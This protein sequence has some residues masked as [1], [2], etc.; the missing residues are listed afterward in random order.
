MCAAFG[1]GA[2]VEAGCNYGSKEPEMARRTVSQIAPATVNRVCNSL[3]AA[4]E[5]AR[6]HDPLRIKNADAW[7][8]GLAGP[9]NAQTAGNVVIDDDT[10]QSLHRGRLPIRSELLVDVLATTGARP[11]QGNCCWSAEEVRHPARR[12]SLPRSGK[13]GSRP[14]RKN[15]ATAILR[16]AFGWRSGEGRLR[17]AARRTRR[18]SCAA[19]VRLGRGPRSRHYA[20]SDHEVVRAI[21]EDPRHHVAYCLRHSNITRMLLKNIPIRLIASLHNTSIHQIEKNYSRRSPSIRPTP[22]RAVLSEP[23]WHRQCRHAGA[24]INRGPQVKR[25]TARGAARRKQPGE[26]GSRVAEV[27]WRKSKDG[28]SVA[29]AGQLAKQAKAWRRP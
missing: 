2:F 26:Q 16:S 21:G 29:L 27:S 12:R 19:M 28:S 3:C 7:D 1:R 25:M 18:C 11:I 10:V 5:L 17:R 24:V 23:P 6:L 13:G 9:P 8:I 4:L 15:G 20:L 22:C 14:Q